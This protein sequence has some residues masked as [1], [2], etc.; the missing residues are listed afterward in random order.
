[1]SEALRQV[2][3]LDWV[4][5]VG[6]CPKCGST[7][8]IVDGESS[9]SKRWWLLSENTLTDETCVKTRELPDDMEVVTD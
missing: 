8:W 7:L 4:T 5:D 3:P 6:P 9:H 2:R 1:M